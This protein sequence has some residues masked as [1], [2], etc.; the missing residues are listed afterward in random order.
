VEA[1]IGFNHMSLYWKP[2][3]LP[4]K[5]LRQPRYDMNFYTVIPQYR[6]YW[7]CDEFKE[8]AVCAYNQTS[9][10]GRGHFS[11]PTLE[12]D[13]N[14]LA[15]MPGDFNPDALEPEAYQYEGL[16]S[17]PDARTPQTVDE[18]ILPEFHMSTY[19]GDV[20]SWRALFPNA[21]LTGGGSTFFQANQ[22]YFFQ[23]QPR[24]PSHWNMTYDAGSGLISVYL[25]GSAGMCGDGF[26]QAKAEQEDM[27]GRKL[28]RG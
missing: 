7:I 27:G 18:W 25:Q 21:F 24:L 8:P 22:F 23:T 11:M 4:P 6:A 9:F 14:F 3:G 15:N 5:G 2:C 16:T 17:F 26:D 28:R 1:T 12:R 19:D 20:V 13:P 10:L